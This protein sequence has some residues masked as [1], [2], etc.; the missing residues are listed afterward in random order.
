M[1]QKYFCQGT[2][3]HGHFYEGIKAT[4]REVKYF[5]NPSTFDATARL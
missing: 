3:L 4:N 5:L 2:H 1:E